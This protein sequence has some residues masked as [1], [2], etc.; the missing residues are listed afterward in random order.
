MVVLLGMC[1][2]YYFFHL[3]NDI[4][5]QHRNQCNPTLKTKQSYHG[6]QQHNLISLSLRLSFGKTILNLKATLLVLSNQQTRF[7]PQ[8]T[9]PQLAY[10]T[11]MIHSADIVSGSVTSIKSSCIYKVHGRQLKSHFFPVSA[12][13]KNLLH[14]EIRSSSAGN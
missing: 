13:Y 9:L 6:I 1:G 2:Y 11:K 7:H 12:H 4:T 3:H 14:H 5:S 8:V 10:L